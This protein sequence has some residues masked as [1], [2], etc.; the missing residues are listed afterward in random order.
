MP[1]DT[2]SSPCLLKMGQVRTTRAPFWWR[3]WKDPGL[4]KDVTLAE[5]HHVRKELPAKLG[6]QAAEQQDGHSWP[7]AHP[8]VLRGRR[9][10]GHCSPVSS[11][12][13]TQHLR[14][15]EYDLSSRWTGSLEMGL[16]MWNGDRNLK[17]SQDTGTD[18]T[19]KDAA[20]W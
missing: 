8:K 5:A 11:H 19:R 10:L 13:G 18:R 4:V 20:H 14:L 1:N 16:S 17:S 12:Q 7:K 2:E 6:H 3:S 15:L 9:D